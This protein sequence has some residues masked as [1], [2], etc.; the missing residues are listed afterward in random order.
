[1]KTIIET[2]YATTVARGKINDST[3]AAQFIMALEE[4]VQELIDALLDDIANVDHELADVILVC[5]N[6]ARHW[7]I[8]IE[9]QLIKNITKNID[10]I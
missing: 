2:N 4:E 3:T 1:M 7:G 8:D 10:R 6:M 9:D 5:L